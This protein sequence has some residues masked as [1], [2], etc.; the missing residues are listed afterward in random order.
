[1]CGQEPFSSEPTTRAPQAARRAL[2]LALCVCCLLIPGALRAQGRPAGIRVEWKDQLLTVQAEN[3]PLSLILKRVVRLTGVD[4]SGLE[5]VQ[6]Q[7]SV[8]FSGRPLSEGLQVLLPG[9]DYAFAPADAALGRRGQLLIMVRGSANPVAAPAAPL[10]ASADTGEDALSQD[11]NWLEDNPEDDK[12]VA[13]LKKAAAKGDTN[14]LHD[15]VLTGD[16]QVQEAAFEELRKTDL[17]GAMTALSTAAQ[18]DKPA[19]ATQSLALLMR[20]GADKSLILTTLGDDIASTDVAL[21][22][23]VAQALPT[24]GAD[25]M[26]YLQ[27][28]LADSDSAVR[29]A[30]LQAV[31]QDDWAQP[32][33]QQ[34]VNDADPQIQALAAQ[35]LQQMQAKP[36]GQA[37]SQVQ[38]PAQPQLPQPP[39]N[40]TNPDP[41]ADVNAP[42]SPN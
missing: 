3:A 28:A 5:K 19:F 1:M 12:K 8:N 26:T 7:A 23:Y 41:F 34:E 25:A 24:Y 32:L 42:A 39:Q 18:S 27:Q 9:W 40:Q 10:S 16:A 4:V 14:G 37:Q 21:R 20:S 35:I 17:N 6:G 30:T 29:L 33:V 31:S 36:A 22:T 11:V 15:A 13:E 2:A 38:V